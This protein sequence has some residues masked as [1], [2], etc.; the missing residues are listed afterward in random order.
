L[1]PS[2]TF[3]EDEN[4]P[5]N[6]A[7]YA[8]DI[9][10]ANLTLTI[11][12]NVNVTVAIVGLDVTLGALLNWNGTEHLIFT[13]S[14]N[15]GRAIASDSTNIIVSPV[16]DAPIISSFSP[17]DT[18]L[19]LQLNNTQLFSVIASDV[20]SDIS[21]S[22]FI[23]EVNQNVSLSTFEYQF[24]Q[25]S[26][27][28]VKVAVTDGIATVEQIWTVSIP[29]VNDDPSVTPLITRLYPNYPNPFNPETTIQYSLKSP[30][31]VDIS[32]YNIAG[33][34]IRDLKKGIEE[35]GMH[36]ITWNGRDNDNQAVASGLYYVRMRSNDGFNIVKMM[37]MK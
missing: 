35:S 34:L 2:F 13:V 16:N 27:H 28:I 14:D 19:T 3:A 21:Y 7:L 15:M 36:S 4:L 11:S 22:W 33:Q 6:V 9:D 10:N 8:S 30:G 24:T 1:P 12:G 18:T 32:I 26:T 23:N 37:L 20:D 5:V 25:S 17:E 29:V 31:W